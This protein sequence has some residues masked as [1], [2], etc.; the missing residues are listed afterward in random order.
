MEARATC[1]AAIHVAERGGRHAI[2]MPCENLDFAQLRGGATERRHMPFLSTLVS[3]STY[4]SLSAL[5]MSY[6]RKLR[7]AKARA[8]GLD[9]VD[10]TS[11]RSY[12]GLG[13]IS[14]PIPLIVYFGKTRRRAAG[15]L[16]GAT[17]ALALMVVNVV[18]IT[19]V[20]VLLGFALASKTGGS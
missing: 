17:I 18:G 19:A 4:L 20:R 10:F 16:L 13:I 2:H 7:R 14:G 9:F 1:R 12:L 3:L 15:Y 8:D 6:D 11:I 5:V